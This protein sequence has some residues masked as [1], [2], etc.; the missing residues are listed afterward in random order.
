MGPR[1][2]NPHLL[3]RISS[4]TL[5]VTPGVLAVGALTAAVVAAGRGLAS[6]TGTATVDVLGSG[7]LSRDDAG[8]VGAAVDARIVD[9]VPLTVDGLAG[10]ERLVVGLPLVGTLLTAAV[11][12]WLCAPLFR[13]LRGGR[14]FSQAAPARLNR[15]AGA[16]VIG[17]AAVTLADWAAAAVVAAKVGETATAVVD[18][19]LHVDLTGLLL[20]WI[21]LF[22]REA[23]WAGRRIA[24]DVEGLV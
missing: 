24:D 10:W 21:I 2:T 22:V 4:L 14:P 15:V 9:R 18:A 8:V 17:W 13:D 11:V 20:A 12:L 6:S 3:R 7:R 16:V 19:N 1:P 5:G 23:A